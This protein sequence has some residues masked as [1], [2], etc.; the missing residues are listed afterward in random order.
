MNRDY[1]T[2]RATSGS[3]S[4]DSTN[5]ASRNV[6]WGT[7]IRGAIQVGHGV[8]EAL[9]GSLGASDVG[10]HKYTSSGEI[11]QRGRHEI[12]QGIA[13]FK[14]VTTM[15]PPAPVYDRRHSYPTQQ[16]EQQPAS[17]WTRRS[18]S[19]HH[20]HHNPP[21][22]SSPFE[23]FYEHPHVA[24]QDQ[25]PGFAGLGAGIDPTRRKE[26]NDRIQ[27]AFIVPPPLVV[28]GGYHNHPMPPNSS[29]SARSFI[30]PTLPPRNSLHPSYVAPYGPTSHGLGL[31]S[32]LD[33]SHFYA[34]APAHGNGSIP[35][36]PT[37]G[38]SSS[39]SPS[40]HSFANLVD[41]T[42][43][44]IR[45]TGK[46]KGKE[47]QSE[48]NRLDRKRSMFLSSGRRTRPPSPEL[49]D[50]EYSAP[51]TRSAPPT[52]PPH[53][54]ESALETAGYDDTYHHWPTAEEMRAS[55]ETS[56]SRS[57]NGGRLEPVRSVRR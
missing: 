25:D 12:A 1:L 55:M 11:A 39:H 53:R 50:H 26:A 5:G 28:S 43:K 31:P 14:G 6:S 36:D 51:Q 18:A 49:P 24:E 32:S 13:R 16:Y 8:G 33:S 44:S 34:P 9:R 41:R 7:K 35:T 22:A 15:L 23:K 2:P 40:R 57:H 10:P 19:A 52:P 20:N 30:P 45:L 17:V 42:S 29:T 3:L 54:H 38:E 47:K 4:R 27:P 37:T 56:R 46:G 21:T 48:G